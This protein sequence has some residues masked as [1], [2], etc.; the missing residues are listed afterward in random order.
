M[1]PDITTKSPFI[2]W[3]N[4]KRVLILSPSFQTGDV[5]YGEGK[6]RYITFAILIKKKKWSYYKKKHAT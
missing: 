1:C 3:Q 4:Q 5:V 2:M 6:L